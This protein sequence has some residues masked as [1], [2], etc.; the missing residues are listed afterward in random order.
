MDLRKE[1]HSYLFR[2]LTADV[3]R[4][5]LTEDGAK[6]GASLYQMFA[7]RFCYKPLTL[8]M[9]NIHDQIAESIMDE[10]LALE[11]FINLWLFDYVV[12]LS[13]YMDG[14]ETNGYDHLVAVV[15]TAVTRYLEDPKIPVGIKERADPHA[16]HTPLVMLFFLMYDVVVQ[17]NEQVTLNVRKA[18]NTR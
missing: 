10:D 16:L 4:L 1:A 8:L 3:D 9:A 6:Q 13:T 11:E 17:F 7:S 5:R 12:G 15:R 2:R 18:E 14:L